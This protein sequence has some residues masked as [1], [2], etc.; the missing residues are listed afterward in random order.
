M[1]LYS[2]RKAS[3]ILRKK[4]RRRPLK[5]IKEKR[6]ASSSSN[7]RERRRPAGRNPLAVIASRI[8]ETDGGWV[9][10]SADRREEEG[11]RLLAST[12]KLI[13]VPPARRRAA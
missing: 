7:P 6:K 3:S 8:E 5:K 4:E 9:S 11:R 10:I 1:G 12:V 13:S 2:P